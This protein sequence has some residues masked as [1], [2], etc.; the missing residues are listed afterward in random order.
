M[1]IELFFLVT[2]LSFA[3]LI[4]A[5]MEGCFSSTL[6]AHEFVIH[7]NKFTDSN[8]EHFFAQITSYR[9]C[10]NTQNKCK[11]NYFPSA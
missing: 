9:I 5:N 10:N 1:N 4:A 7:N 11:D 3:L 2:C 6:P 8:P